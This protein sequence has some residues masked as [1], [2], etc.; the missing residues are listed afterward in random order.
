MN[1]W[2]VYHSNVT[3]SIKYY[4]VIKCNTVVNRIFVTLLS[5]GT[6]RPALALG[7]SNY[8]AAS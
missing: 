8:K 6:N 1:V 3:E 4:V 2:K 7:V 5:Y